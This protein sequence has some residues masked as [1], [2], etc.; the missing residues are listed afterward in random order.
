M[1]PSVPSPRRQFIKSAAMI[2]TG[3]IGLSMVPGNTMASPAPE[4]ERENVLGPRS[5]FSLHVG[6]LLS[7]MTWMRQTIL[8]PV[9]AMSVEQLD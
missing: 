4:D 9:K 8:Y 7:T 5:G 2:T 3:S 6:T 1:N